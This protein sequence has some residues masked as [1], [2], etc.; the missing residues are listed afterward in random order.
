MYKNY[1][2]ILEIDK[3]S[4]INE[5]K[6]TYKKPNNQIEGGTKFKEISEAYKILCFP[7]K[8]KL[9]DK[10]VYK[11]LNYNFSNNHS[12]FNSP[13]EKFNMF[14][15]MNNNNNHCNSDNSNNSNNSNLLKYI[16]RGTGIER[17]ATN[18]QGLQYNPSDVDAIY[19]NAVYDKIQFSAKITLLYFFFRIVKFYFR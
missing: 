12:T 4:S 16:Y 8:K 14:F 19:V 13:D 11:E 10:N 2:Y 7:E 15:K 18:K 6:K 17:N 1:Y 9:Y 5:I 3:N